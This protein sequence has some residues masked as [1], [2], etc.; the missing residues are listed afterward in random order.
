MGLVEETPPDRPNGTA[1]SPTSSFLSH[2]TASQEHF[3]K[4]FLL[5]EE[6]SKELHAFSNPNCCEILGYPFKSTTYLSTQPSKDL[7]LLSFFFRHFLATFPFITNNSPTD[8]QDFWQHTLQP[9]IESFNSKPISGSL[10][11]EEHVTKRRQVNKKLLSGLLLFYN[12]VIITDQELAYL[13]D[14]HLKPS[15]TGKIDK[16]QK[17]KRVVPGLSQLGKIKVLGVRKIKDQQEQKQRSWMMSFR[18]VRRSNYQ[19]ILEFEDACLVKTYHQFSTLHN[20]LKKQFPGIMSEITFPRKHK[21]D[22]GWA[23]A[24]VNG[25]HYSG[26]VSEPSDRESDTVRL[27]SKVL[28][29]EKLR[30]ALRGYLSALIKIPEVEHSAVLLRFLTTDK[31]KLTAEDEADI[32]QRLEHEDIMKQTQVE[33]Q[34]QTTKIMLQLTEDFDDFKAKMVMNPDMI[35]SLFAELGANPDIKQLSP[36]LQTFNEWCKVEIAATIYQTFVSQDNSQEWFN[37]VRKFHRLFPYGILYQ[38]L[39]VI[40]PTTIISKVINLF[41]VELPSWPWS[42]G[43]RGS[44]LSM[45]FIMLLN[46]DLSDFRKELVDLEEKLDGYEVYVERIQNY[47]TLLIDAINTIRDEAGGGEDDMLMT[48]LSTKVLSP[49]LSN[50]DARTLEEIETSYQHYQEISEKKDLAESE[51]YMNLKQ[52]WQIQVRCRDKD[53]IKQLWQEPELTELIKKFLTLFYQPLMT[54]FAKSDIHIAF[55]GLQRFMDDLVATVSKI[56]EEEIYYLDTFDIYNKLKALLD[57]HESVIWEFIHKIYVKDDQHLFLHLVQWFEKFLTLMRIKF[58]EPEMVKIHLPTPA[59]INEELF[60]KQLDAHVD[61]T[62]ARRRL[63]KEY[64]EA[65]ANAQDQIDADWED[66]NNQIFGNADA[67]EFGVAD[68]DIEEFNHLNWEDDLH[69]LTKQTN[70]EIELIQKLHDLD[71]LNYGTDELLKLDVKPEFIRVLSNIGK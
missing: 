6:L 46:E 64:L 21:N 27:N 12:S 40:N 53:L 22:D 71:K 45:I 50:E 19:F 44:L 9:F 37:K 28:V 2:L 43:H 23:D 4:K 41:L 58:I 30:L 51:L 31:T 3:L 20:D 1:S 17:N 11:R 16:F 52:Y 29:R 24:D 49:A 66:I 54:I 33:F 57:R 67:S 26:S 32:E 5:E 15:D 56:N 10:E 25:S 65:K 60:L 36:V 13:S 69:D 48:I 35:S 70:L 62:I 7:P 47:T 38:M 63:F 61:K 68:E 42:S 39:R 14:T 8:Q 18:K 59:D 55:R 34:Q